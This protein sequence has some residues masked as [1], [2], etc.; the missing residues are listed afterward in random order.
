MRFRESLPEINRLSIVSAAIMLAFALTQLV[1][2]PAQIFS[3]SIFGILVE[4]ILD[5]STII[6]ILTTLMSAAGMHWLIIS[7]PDWEPQENLWEVI[8]HWIVP[9]LTA[10]VI[11]VALN[12]F[13]GS[14][15]WWV[16]YILGS[17]LLVAVFI[18]EFNVVS[19][20]GI[21]HPFA[22]VGLTGLSFA[23][24]LLLAIAIF[25]ANL[26]L[27]IRIPLLLTAAMMVISRSLYL[28]LK[29]WETLWA[30]IGSLIV[31]ELAIGLHYLPLSPIQNGILLVGT[32]YILTIIVLGIKENRKGL[33]FWL[34]PITM[35]VLFIIVSIVMV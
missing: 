13:S 27:Y 33:R 11:G 9:V 6:T 4:L 14:S 32:G 34:E 25:S 2:F 8:Q 3:F 29:S 31:S 18:A 22:T 15:L 28:R 10:L 7:H 1:S 16:V 21:R 12:S 24:Y 5:F 20:K 30:A 17:V 23:L 19:E 35:F 26:R